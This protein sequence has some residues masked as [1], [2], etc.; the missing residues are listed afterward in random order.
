MSITPT[1]QGA[2]Y[3]DF[4]CLGV[5]LGFFVIALCIARF[6]SYVIKKAVLAKFSFCYLIHTL[7]P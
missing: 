6:H 4:G 5:F 2:L 7:N 1:L 3:V